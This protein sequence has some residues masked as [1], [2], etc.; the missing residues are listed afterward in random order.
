MRLSQP[1]KIRCKQDQSLLLQWGY[2]PPGTD[3]TCQCGK[4]NQTVNHLLTCEK[5]EQPAPWMT[6]YNV[7]AMPKKNCNGL[8][9][10]NLAQTDSKKKKRYYIQMKKLLRQ[11]PQTA[12]KLCFT[13]PHKTLQ[14]LINSNFKTDRKR[15]T[16]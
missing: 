8:V 9:Q 16:R 4:E 2:L 13:F 12:P 15:D 3:T 5:L 7:T 14:F 1:F 10:L 11:N 6:Y